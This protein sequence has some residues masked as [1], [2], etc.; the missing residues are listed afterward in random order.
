[1]PVMTTKLAR[2]EA[3][4]AAGE[5]LEALRIAA[6]F[7]WLGEYKERIVRGWSAHTSPE[8]YRGMGLDPDALVADAVAAIRERYGIGRDLT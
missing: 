7:P 2:L 8:M 1:M 3:H 5:T 6:K 4:M